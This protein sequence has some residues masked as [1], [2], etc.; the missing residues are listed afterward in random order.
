MPVLKLLDGKF[1]SCE[2]ILFVKLSYASTQLIGRKI[3]LPFFATNRPLLRNF[4]IQNYGA[5]KFKIPYIFISSIK[6]QV[7]QYQYRKKW[8]RSV[9]YTT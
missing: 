4:D 5:R 1:V 8:E 7:I 3:C 2:D 9:T 6:V